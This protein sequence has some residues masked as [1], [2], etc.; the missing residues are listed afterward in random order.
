[1]VCKLVAT[2]ASGWTAFS[3]RLISSR[4][5]I[6]IVALWAGIVLVTATLLAAL[7]PDPRATWWWCI[8]LTAIVVPL[9]RILLAPVALAWNR[10][11]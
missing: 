3:K 8:S 5:M 4:E 10:H 7:I 9:A 1:L 2:M 6:T 11:R